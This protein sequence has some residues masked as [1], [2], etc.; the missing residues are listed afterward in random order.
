MGMSTWRYSRK[1]RSISPRTLFAGIVLVISIG[2]IVTYGYQHSI[3][4]GATEERPPSVR[5]I[6]DQEIKGYTVPNA[7]SRYITIDAIN[8]HTRVVSV[9]ILK[10]KRMQSPSNVFDVGWFTK[11]ALPGDDGAV[12]MDGHISSAKTRGV[13]Y[14]LKDL[15]KGD[16]VSVELGGGKTVSYEVVKS[17]V[18]DVDKIDMVKVQQPIEGKKGLNL[19]SC[20]GKVIKGTREFDKRI[21]VFTKQI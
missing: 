19:I 13:F 8:V 7:F 14:R 17:D 3:M 21:I 6:T 2:G 12:V 4:G 5:Q 16:K 10:D 1:K 20:T 11:S 15:K 18:Q 9:G